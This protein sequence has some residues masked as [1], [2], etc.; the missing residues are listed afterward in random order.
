M[1]EH[2]DLVARFIEAVQVDPR[3]VIAMMAVASK[4][5]KWVDPYKDTEEL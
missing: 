4:M 1:P 3:Y 2:E 5:G